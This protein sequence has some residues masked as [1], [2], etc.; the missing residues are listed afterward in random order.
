MDKKPTPF[1]RAVKAAKTPKGKAKLEARLKK[2]RDEEHA[3]YTIQDH[4]R[5]EKHLE[6]AKKYAKEMY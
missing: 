6:S 5:T 1:D 3:I 4:A 2:L